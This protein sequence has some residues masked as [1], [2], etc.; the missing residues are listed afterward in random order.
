M[1][2]SDAD[3]VVVGAALVGAALALFHPTTGAVFL[4]LVGLGLL[5]DVHQRL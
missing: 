5:W 4:L 1:L 3:Q 2:N